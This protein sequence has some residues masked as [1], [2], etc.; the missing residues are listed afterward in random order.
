MWA[1]IS[2]SL[3]EQVLIVKGYPWPRTRRRHESGLMLP[4]F[5]VRVRVCGPSALYDAPATE[6]AS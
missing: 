2:D 5:L 3:L 6:T 1:T 4:V